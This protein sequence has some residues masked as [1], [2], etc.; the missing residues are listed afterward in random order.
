MKNRKSLLVSELAT[1][2]RGNGVEGTSYPRNS[3]NGFNIKNKKLFSKNNGL[4]SLVVASGFSL[5]VFSQGTYNE[6]QNLEIE[7]DPQL[8]ISLPT[9]QPSFFGVSNC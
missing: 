7:L 5:F 3:H 9:F 8:K 6:G 2:R 1:F 4:N